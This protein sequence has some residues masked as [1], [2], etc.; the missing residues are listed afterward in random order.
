MT[1]TPTPLPPPPLPER[2]QPDRLR[3][4]DPASLDAEAERLAAVERATRT[5]M[6]PYERQLR[7]I[8]VR[9]EEVATERRRRERAD[10]HAAR[11]SVR[12]LAGGAE[13]PSL[14]AAL[15]AEPSPLPDE[16]PL[17]A[18]RAL[19]AS[20]GEVG[21]G[22]PSRP[23]SVGF[24]DGRQLRNAG[25][26][27]EARRLYADGWEPGAPGAAGVR[28]VRVHLSGTRVERVVEPDEVLVDLR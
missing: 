2:V 13:L 19:L 24:T 6:A 1:E 21:F 11:V 5:S 25:T 9:R 8:R 26:W 7:E 18:V 28:G 17:A 23:G 22:Y 16:R 10:R 20:G 14:A 4:L 15:L 27:G 3:E 12:E